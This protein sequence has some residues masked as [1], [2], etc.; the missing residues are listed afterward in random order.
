MGVHPF[1]MDENEQKLGQLY[2]KIFMNFVKTG[3]PG[4]GFHMAN[5]QNS[6]YFEVFWDE[7]N[8]KR[9]GMKSGFEKHVGSHKNVKHNRISLIL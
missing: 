4:E 7:K 6:T 5:V 9:P 3:H 2:R 1:E 8:G